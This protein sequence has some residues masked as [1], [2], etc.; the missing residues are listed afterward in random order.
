MDTHHNQRRASMHE[1]L[2]LKTTEVRRTALVLSFV[3]LKKNARF[4]CRNTMIQLTHDFVC[5]QE[6]P[7]LATSLNFDSRELILIFLG[8]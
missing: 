2:R 6:L 7:Y 5:S 1:P 3:G 8:N 4:E